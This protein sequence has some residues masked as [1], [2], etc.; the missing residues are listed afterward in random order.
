MCFAGSGGGGGEVVRRLGQCLVRA[1]HRQDIPT[2]L[3]K[4]H[5][6]NVFGPKDGK[7]L[8]VMPFSGDEVAVARS[9]SQL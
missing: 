1:L 8:Y 4:S 3:S 9:N 2:F 5:G 6:E 7:N